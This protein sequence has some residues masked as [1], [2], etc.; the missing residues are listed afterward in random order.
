MFPSHDRVGSNIGF[1]ADSL[2]SELSSPAITF[3]QQ[4]LTDELARQ[5]SGLQG[6]WQNLLADKQ[7]ALGFIDSY[8]RRFSG[9]GVRPTVFPTFRS[10][11]EAVGYSRPEATEIALSK[12]EGLVRNKINEGVRKNLMGA[13]EQR[14]AFNIQGVPVGSGD[15][16]ALGQGARTKDSI[17]QD[18]LRRYGG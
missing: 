9:G 15:V 6:N 8:N 18:L 16:S 4:Q 3:N 10:A 11:L 2:G 12:N 5:E 1:N 17:F 14:G 7:R 13:A